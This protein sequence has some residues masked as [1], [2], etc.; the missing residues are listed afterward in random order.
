VLEVGR[1]LDL[2]QEALGA[3]HG[4][5]LGAEELES[6]L[7]VV[8]EILGQVDRRHPAGADL[9]FDPVAVGE[10][11]LEPVEQLGHVGLCW[12]VLTRCHRGGI[13]ASLAGHRPPAA[14]HPSYGARLP[15]AR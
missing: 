10:R 2:G 1:Q 6:D 9:A 4:R 5:E 14:S 3:D 13:G 11:Y 15:Q 12:G 8:S 7:A